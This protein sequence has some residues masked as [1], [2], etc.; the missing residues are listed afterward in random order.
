[1]LRP[2]IFLRYFF[3]RQP[4]KSFAEI[5]EAMH[6]HAQA[7]RLTWGGV[8]RT[9]RGHCEQVQRANPERNRP[10]LP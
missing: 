2:Y 10:R 9:M 7:L 5:S 3:V 8:A 4:I 6:S 1:M